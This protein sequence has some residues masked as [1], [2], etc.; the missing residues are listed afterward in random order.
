MIYITYLAAYRPCHKGGHPTKRLVALLFV[1][2]FLA[3]SASHAYQQHHIVFLFSDLADPFSAQIRVC[4]ETAFAQRDEHMEVM[5]A[6]GSF[7]A[8]SDQVMDAAASGADLVCIQ[9]CE[10]AS[11]S[12]AQELLDP[13]EAAGIPVI[14]FG[15]SIAP[16]HEKLVRFLS[17]HPDCLYV[18]HDVEDIGRVQGTSIGEYLCAHYTDCDLNGDG[19]ISFVCFQGDPYDPDAVHRSRFACDLANQVLEEA[20]YPALQWYDGS[21]CCALADPQCMWSAAFARDT[22]NDLLKVYSPASGNMIELIICGCDDMANGCINAL[23]HI[24]LNT[25][26]PGSLCIPVFGVDGTDLA[27]ELIQKKRMTG[28]VI[29]SPEHMVRSLTAAI[30]FV[31]DAVPF[32]PQTERVEDACVFPLYEYLGNR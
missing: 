3:P 26:V 28:T 12:A 30:S 17:D 22:L 21:D 13:L 14:F 7:R 5:D 31:L 19:I 8:Q 10:Y 15:R 27:R 9:S 32:D 2:F 23:F 29:R 1:L 25:D 20:G 18:N 6:H 24:D 4:L 11:L 16:S